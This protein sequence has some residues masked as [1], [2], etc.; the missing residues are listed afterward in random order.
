MKYLY[1]PLI[2]FCVFATTL[3]AQQQGMYT[4]YMFNG[5]ALNPAYAGSQESLNFTALARKQWAGIKGSPSTQTFSAHSP[6]KRKNKVALGFLFSN[7]YIGV[8]K[9]ISVNF[10]YAYR[11]KVGKGK[12]SMGLQGGF[13]NY[14]NAYTSLY[15]GPD[16]VDPKFLQNVNSFT[17]VVGA[18][19]LYYT[20]RFYAGISSPQLISYAN[21]SAQGIGM[22]QISHY[23][24]SSGYVFDLSESL[25][26]KPNVLVKMVTGAPVQIDI[27]ANLLINEVVWLGISY[28]SLESISTL[29]QVDVTHQL[30]FGYS[31]DIP[32]R[33]KL[34]GVNGGSH[35]L[36]LNYNF[37]FS[38]NKRRVVS[39]RYF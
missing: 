11:I 39:P 7:D 24:I 14:N 4:Q 21:K 30:T 5:L 15:L 28:R 8:T 2:L 16:A 13:S 1:L 29:L 32:A 17:P 22:K 33:Y 38:K 37:A 3:H 19:L 35:E 27:N 23:F 25:K 10:A 18:G 6:L 9:Q 26:L 31:Y 34:G 12:F 36:M 20:Q